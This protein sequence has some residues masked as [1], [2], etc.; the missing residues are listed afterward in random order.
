MNADSP[1]S[2]IVLGASAG[3]VEALTAT[4]A[5]LPP[6]ID[7]AIFAVIHMPAQSPSM[8]AAILDRA[9]PLPVKQA[10]DGAAIQAGRVYV[11][12]PDN[13]LV[14]E[15]GVMRV[16]HGPRENRYR[17]SIDVLFRTAAN[18][19]GRRVIGVVLTGSLDDGTAGLIAIKRQGGLAIV[20]DPD[21]AVYPSMP[22]SALQHVAVD[23]IVR[24]AQL[25]AVLAHLTATM[26]SYALPDLAP[27]ASPPTPEMEA[28]M[29]QINDLPGKP[30]PYS[31]PECHG[32]LW[33]IQDGALTRFRCRVGHAFS[34]ESML[35]EQS[36]TLEVALWSALKTLE[37]S[38][39]L[40]RRLEAQSTERGHQHMARRFAE[41]AATAE[42]RALV[43]RQVLLTEESAVADTDEDALQRQDV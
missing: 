13:H 2:I 22:R 33:E 31:C 39:S 32:V 6:V 23:H 37:E 17:P 18:A 8:L 25:P 16:V 7:A 34:P 36:D 41:K 12:C 14:L 40:S 1:R 43:I 30:S 38:A 10:S 35:A 11:A 28:E 5:G 15:Q 20:Q 26:P 24:L 27:A 42:R 3:G 19:Y 9:G 21:E 29:V 4:M